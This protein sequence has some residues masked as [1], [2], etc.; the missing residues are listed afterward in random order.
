[1][2]RH[3]DPHIDGQHVVGADSGDLSFLYNAQ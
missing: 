2:G 3:D 1:M